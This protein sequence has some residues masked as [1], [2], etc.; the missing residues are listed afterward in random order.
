ME[1]AKQATAYFAAVFLCLELNQRQGKRLI[2]H[3]Q[4]VEMEMHSPRHL[5]LILCHQQFFMEMQS[6]VVSV[7]EQAQAWHC[8][9]QGLYVWFGHK[10]ISTYCSYTA[11]CQAQACLV[12]VLLYYRIFCVLLCQDNQAFTQQR[13][14]ALPKRGQACPYNVLLNVYVRLCVRL[15]SHTHT[16]THTHT[17]RRL[18]ER[19][20]RHDFLEKHGLLNMRKV[21]ALDRRRTGAERDTHARLRVFARYR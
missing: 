5:Y 3:H 2:L 1:T 21:Q 7:I 11:Q 15:C 19:E 14:I 4:L 10:H 20:A 18:D 8:A 12:L 16:H 13:G 17:R 6:N 9:V